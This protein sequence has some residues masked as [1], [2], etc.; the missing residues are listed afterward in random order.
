[1]QS[2]E[3]ILAKKR[4][5]IFSK[6]HDRNGESRNASR[7]RKKILRKGAR[8]FFFYV[9]LKKFCFC[10]FYLFFCCFLWFF[11]WHI[12][13]FD[14]YIFDHFVYFYSFFLFIFGLKKDLFAI[15]LMHLRSAERFCGFLV[16]PTLHSVQK[17]QQF[18]FASTYFKK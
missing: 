2:K 1:M 15:A 12:C 4:L 3:M 13:A 11:F 5:Y 6:K 16:L 10:V 17:K 18:K 14:M 9:S 8:K 7:R